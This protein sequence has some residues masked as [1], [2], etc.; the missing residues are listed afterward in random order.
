[1]KKY[2]KIIFGLLL[3]SVFIPAMTLAATL[4]SNQIQSIIGLLQ[5]FGADSATVANVQSALNGGS[6]M[7]VQYGIY[8][9]IPAGFAFSRNLAMGS[10]G[11]DV[12]YLK[13]ILTAENCFSASTSNNAFGS[14]TQTGVKCFQKKY[15]I[16]PAGAVGPITMAKLDALIGG[17]NPQANPKTNANSS[18][19]NLAQAMSDNAQ[20]STISFDGLAFITGSAGADTFFPPG[21]VADYFGFQYMRDVDAAGYGHNTTFLTKAANNVIYILNDDQKAKLIALAKVQAP[22]YV[23]FAYNRFLL[24]NAFRRN[25]EGKIPASSTGLA[26]SAVSEYTGDLYKTDADLAYNRALVVGGVIN[27]LTDVQKAYLAKMQFDD[28]STWPD[29]AENTA[30][31]QGLNNSEYTALMTYASEL[32]SWYKGGL[33]ADIYFCPERHGTYFGGF[34]MKDYAAVGNN[35]Y[36]ISTSLTGDSGQGF[37][38]VLNGTQRA[39]ITGIIDEQR[40][41]L[42]EIAQLRTTISTELRKTISGGMPD[43]DLVYASVHH[44]GVLDGQLSALYATRFAQ[45]KA[46]LTDA[47]MAALVKLRNLTVV[48]QGAYLFSTPVDMPTIP[49]TDF[50]FGAG[51][52]PENEGQTTPPATFT[53]ASAIN[54]APP[55]A[56][57]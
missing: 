41:T 30:I 27:S 18:Q 39:M 29:V 50:L 25:L 49:S 55:P 38:N 34:F 19:Y 53:S 3:I 4:T 15:G 7:P 42:Q 54:P 5:S 12:S 14:L 31:K 20:L 43:K 17:K 26:T 16:N 8:A 11:Q 45:V 57:Q 21:K 24:S 2:T 28:S 1:M 33:D 56:G 47:Q 36:F 40:S 10:T 44:Y 13:I 9:G 23:N 48:P 35:D 6:S 22:M 52:V 32:F 46:T 51:S 37:L